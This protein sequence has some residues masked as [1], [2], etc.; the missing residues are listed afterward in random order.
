[1]VSRTLA[2]FFGIVFGAFA[3]EGC[4]TGLMVVCA[5]VSGPIGGRAAQ[6]SPIRPIFCA[7]PLTPRRPADMSEKVTYQ[8]DQP[9]Y[10]QVRYGAEDSTLVIVVVDRINRSQFDLYVDADRDRIIEPQERV[11]RAGRIRR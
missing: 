5:L 7:V 9:L 10:A 2:T 6:P 8:N 1:M 4:G 11:P 3:G